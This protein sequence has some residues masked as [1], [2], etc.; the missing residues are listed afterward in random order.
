LVGLLTA[1]TLWIAGCAAVGSTGQSTVPTPVTPSVS[2]SVTP[3]SAVVLLGNT[4]SF[5]AS[6][7]NSENASVTW[8]VNAVSGGNASLGTITAAGLYTAPVDLLAGG[9]SAVKIGAIS[10]ADPSQS[11]SS[12]VTVTSDVSVALTD[13]AA[14]AELGAV[15]QFHAAI[16]S[17]GHPNLGIQWSVGGACLTQCG[18]VDGSGQFTAPQILPRAGVVTVTAQSVADPSKHASQHVPITSGYSLQTG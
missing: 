13:T 3:A 2:V 9:L 5:T 18:S 12:Q 7:M 8:S 15:E 10:Q 17:E 11:A 16:A 4:Q 14:P 1:G 6:V